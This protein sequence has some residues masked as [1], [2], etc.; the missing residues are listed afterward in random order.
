MLDSIF[1][2]HTD[3][4]IFS[5]AATLVVVTV[6]AIGLAVAAGQSVQKALQPVAVRHAD[7]RMPAGRRPR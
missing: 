6:A 2:I 5:V 3:I 1:A 4:N 7:R